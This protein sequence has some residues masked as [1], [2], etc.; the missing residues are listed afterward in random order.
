[1]IHIVALALIFFV[2]CAIT[3]VTGGTALVT[4]PAMILFGIPARTALATNM[5]TLTMMSVGGTLPFLRGEEFDRGR[6]PLLIALTM[7]GSVIGALLV[8]AVPI[9][10]LPLII[11]FAMVVVLVFLVAN[12]RMGIRGET[13]LSRA[14]IVTGYAAALVLGIYGG[15]FSGGYVTLLMASFVFFFGYSFLRSMAMSRLMNIASSF[16]AT[17]VFAWHGAIEWKLA[18][19]L[20]IA[21]FAGAFVGARWAKRVPE[22]WLRRVFVTAVALLA[23]KSFAV[24]IPWSRI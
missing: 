14:R 20:G 24:D 11:P 9:E 21:A 4:V 13:H 5:V 7:T 8:F 1:M 10:L 19:E 22:K 2:T 16:I 12:P 6:V 15:F 23:L 17:C 3:V 18:G